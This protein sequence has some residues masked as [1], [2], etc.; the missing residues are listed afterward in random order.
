MKIY[1]KLRYLPTGAKR[2][3]VLVK[4]LF[5]QYKRGTKGGLRLMSYCLLLLVHKGPPGSKG[6]KFPDQSICKALCGYSHTPLFTVTATALE[7]HQPC[8]GPPS[9]LE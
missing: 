2:Q 4:L 7:G 1:Q 8:I 6:H 3:S 9:G 5:N